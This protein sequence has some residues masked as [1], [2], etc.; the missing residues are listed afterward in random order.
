MTP[1][2]TTISEY[3]NCYS[4]KTYEWQ[5]LSIID[6]KTYEWQN[7]SSIDGALDI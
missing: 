2:L 6:G 3:M 4:S 1:K 7:L 5:N